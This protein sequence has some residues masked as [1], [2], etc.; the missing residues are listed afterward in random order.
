MNNSVRNGNRDFLEKKADS[1]IVEVT[2]KENW[3]AY[4]T[5]ETVKY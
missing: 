2:T 1:Q 4:K 3:K 5:V